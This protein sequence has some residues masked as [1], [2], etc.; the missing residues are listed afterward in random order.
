[1]ANKM[2]TA[3]SKTIA[4]SDSVAG[5]IYWC[6]QGECMNRTDNI[7]PEVQIAQAENLAKQQLY[8]FASPK[9]TIIKPPASD[10][11]YEFSAK[12]IPAAQ[13]KYEKSIESAHGFPTL[14]YGSSC[15]LGFLPWL[16]KCNF[17]TAG[18]ILKSMYTK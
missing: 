13:I 3:Y 6:A 5:G 14:T 1:M 7:K 16:L 15:T 2:S 11:L 17:D 18:E 8:I 12:Y 10:R 4:G 9:D